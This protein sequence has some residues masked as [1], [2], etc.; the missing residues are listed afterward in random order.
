MTDDSINPR[1][2][3]DTL[4]TLRPCAEGDPYSAA[5]RIATVSQD[6]LE[7]I[8]ASPDAR[9]NAPMTNATSTPHE[10]SAVISGPVS[11]AMTEQRATKI[12]IAAVVGI[13]LALGLAV[14][15]ANVVR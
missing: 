11:S 15:V 8:K 3:R 1:A 4:D 5:T 13:L 2:V 9:S 10:T 14:L 6:V 12:A 7:A